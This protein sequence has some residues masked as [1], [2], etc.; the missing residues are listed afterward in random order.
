VKI[1][2]SSFGAHVTQ[3]RKENVP[4]RNIRLKIETYEKLQKY[5]LNLMQEKGTPWLTL[6]DAVNSLLEGV[7][8]KK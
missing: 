2:T 8:A 1:I 7:I 5:L 4:N 6:D 3:K